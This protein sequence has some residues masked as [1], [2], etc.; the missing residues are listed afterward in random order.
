M[1]GFIIIFFIILILAG[2]GLYKLIENINPSL[3]V[4]YTTDSLTGE[5]HI[6]EINGKDTENI[7]NDVLDF[8]GFTVEE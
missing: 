4:K 5:T 2:I 6:T 1:H 7:K 3:N 8:F